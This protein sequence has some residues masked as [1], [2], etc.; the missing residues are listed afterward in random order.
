MPVPQSA[1]VTH[2]AGSQVPVE[3]VGADP[4]EGDVT[5]TGMLAAQS[6]SGAHLGAGA[7][8]MV[9]GM[10]H[11]KPLAQSLVCSH[12]VAR[13]PGARASRTVR[14]PNARTDFVSD[15]GSPCWGRRGWERVPKGCP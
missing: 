1:S 3:G 11:V 5:G 2:E 14:E 7:G 6:A 15:M 12:S 4:V 8:V 13:A 9:G 10:M